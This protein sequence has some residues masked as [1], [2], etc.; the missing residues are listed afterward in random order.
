MN[1]FCSRCS[2]FESWW[3]ATFR[4]PKAQGGLPLSALYPWAFSTFFGIEALHSNYMYHQS[5]FWTYRNQGK[6]VQHR[7]WS[8]PKVQQ[9]IC[10]ITKILILQSLLI[11]IF[12]L[13]FIPS[14]TAA[15]WN[16]P[17]KV[18]AQPTLNIFLQK[19]FMTEKPCILYVHKVVFIINRNL[20]L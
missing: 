14:I 16:T 3:Y 5:S 12:N 8:T 13:Q 4:A 19:L 11:S 15:P 20:L 17:L 6:S 2:K 1:K 7:L 18:T 9:S 10:G